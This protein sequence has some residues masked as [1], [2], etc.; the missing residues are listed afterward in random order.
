MT[1]G[2]CF[3]GCAGWSLAGDVQTQFGEGASHLQ[4]YASRLNAVEINSSFYRPHRRATYERWAASVPRDFR[5]CVKL[6]KAITHERRLA[7]CDGLLQDFFGQA[8]GLGEKLG[9]LL[10][11]MPPSLAFEATAAD[12]FFRSLRKVHAGHAAVE[13]RHHSWFGAE[14]GAL[15]GAHGLARVL[16]DPV[17]F[18]E[19]RQPGGWDQLVYVRPHGSPRMYYSAYAPELLERLALRIAMAQAEGRA[20]WCMFDNT[21]SG[22]A[23]HNALALSATLAQDTP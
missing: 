6:P 19:G 3:V 10:V 22:A 14:A 15:L 23:T 4:R 11:Q 20:V 16:A 18:D 13:P 5:F 12:A 17:L 2:A 21:A 9:C 7:A 1:P 8:G